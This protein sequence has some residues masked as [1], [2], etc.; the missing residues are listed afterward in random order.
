MPIIGQKI[1]NITAQRGEIKPKIVIASNVDIT[2]IKSR[3]LTLTGG[4][5]PGMDIDFLFTIKYGDTGGKIDING[6]IIYTEDVKEL[7][8]EEK[9]WN[10][11]KKLSS[12]LTI[13]VLNRAMEIGYVNAILAS[14]IIGMPA[15]IQLPRARTAEEQK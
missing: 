7:K 5:K 12:Q 2:D 10:K 15:P 4:N 11:N 3:E 1:N 8:K 9:E 6:T 13:N 14:N